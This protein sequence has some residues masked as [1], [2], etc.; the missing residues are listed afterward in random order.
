VATL[1]KRPG[2]RCVH[3]H[4]VVDVVPAGPAAGRLNGLAGQQHVAQPR[5]DRGDE[6]DEAE[7]G[8][9]PPGVPEVVEH[10]QVLDERRFGIGGER[11]DVPA[12]LGRRT[13]GHRDL[14]LLVR[15]RRAVEQLGD[16]LTALHLHEQYPPA[17]G[18]ES[19][20]QRGRH[21]GLAGTA[22]AGD[23]VQPHALPVGVPSPHYLL[24]VKPH[25]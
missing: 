1:R 16:A 10:L 14:A 12:R 21:R 25:P 18:C 5:R 9:G 24:P 15:Q 11:V 17:S 19:Q 6:V 13:G 4:G 23:H 20:G 22:L 2:R 8:Q 7:P 3:D